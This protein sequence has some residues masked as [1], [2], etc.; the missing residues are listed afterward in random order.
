MNENGVDHI[1]D[2][3]GRKRAEGGDEATKR[4][5]PPRPGLRK[6]DGGR[7][8]QHSMNFAIPTTKGAQDHA[9]EQHGSHSWR[10][11]ALKF[12]HQSWFQKLLMAL[13]L[14]DVIILFT[15]IFLLAQYPSCSIITRDA[16]SC[17]PVEETDHS[18]LLRRFL[19]GG[20]EG[21]CEQGTVAL[22]ESPAGCDEHKYHAVHVAEEV[23]FAFTVTILSVFFIELTVTM[24][25]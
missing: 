13:L 21:I 7:L 20:D 22:E 14:L 25:E 23:L 6:Q 18:E 15:E 9:E 12:I 2:H 4:R 10:Y 16:I 3:I 17:C 1:D 19:S 11:K 8:S 24:G 5:V